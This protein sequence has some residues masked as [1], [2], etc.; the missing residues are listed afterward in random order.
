MPP[1]PKHCL[2][3]AR[4]YETLLHHAYQRQPV[5][6]LAIEMGITYETLRLRISGKTP[7]K[8]EAWYALGWYAGQ[9]LGVAGVTR[10]ECVQC[11][12]W[13]LAVDSATV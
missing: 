11:R 1:T 5:S 2:Q 3:C 13:F 8:S 9:R 10:Y 6:R 7:I 4:N 12:E